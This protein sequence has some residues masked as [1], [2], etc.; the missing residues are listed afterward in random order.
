MN[1]PKK[2]GR[3]KKVV[4]PTSVPPPPDHEQILETLAA[5]ANEPVPLLAVEP[6]EPFEI[7]LQQPIG[8]QEQALPP[9]TKTPPVT[10]NVFSVLNAIEKHAVVQ[11]VVSDDIAFGALFQVGDVKDDKVHGFFVIPGEPKQFI[12]T[13]LANVKLVGKAHIGSHSPCSPEWIS[14]SEE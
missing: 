10:P 3:P 12:T 2:L 6:P 14:S 5:K 11:V 7:S 1:E 8:G 4:E 9:Q 13:K